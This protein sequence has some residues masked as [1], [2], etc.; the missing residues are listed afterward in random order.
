V[1]SVLLLLATSLLAPLLLVDYQLIF[2]A[3]I[4]VWG[5]FA[6]SFGLVY[7]FGGMLSFAQA[8]YFGAGCYG[9]NLATYKFGLGTWGAMGLGTAAAVIFAVPTGYIATRV[10]QHH[11]LIVTVILSV[12]VTAVLTSG[13]WRWIAGP[14]ITRSLPFV[15]EV[16]FGPLT[17]SY[18]SE[19]FSYYFTLA[20]VGL[21]VWLAA[22]VVASPFGRALKA[23]RANEQRAELIGLE[24]NRLRWLMFVFAAGIAGLSG[25]LYV[26]LARY[27]NLEFFEWTYSGKAVVAAVL[28][29]A[30]S[31]A[32][33]FAGMAFYLTVTEHLSRYFQQFA[34]LYGVLL[35][36]VLRFAPA[37][38]YVTAT[39]WL[40]DLLSRRNASGGGPAA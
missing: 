6:L 36:V 33:P 7:G 13:H 39:R 16:S 22:R 20:V 18:G 1:P 29:G 11:F 8:I 2:V 9:F 12:L 19:L 15:P 4:A 14:Y 3:E 32:G 31:L 26:L 25:T 10:R 38:L 30:G 23:I 21:A 40:A 5:L 37:G 27:T 34:I 28:G 17:F 24:V 35:L